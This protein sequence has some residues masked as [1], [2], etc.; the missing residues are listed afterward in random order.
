MHSKIANES[1]GRRRGERESR[2]ER[3]D[4]IKNSGI[5]IPTVLQSYTNLGKIAIATINIAHN[6]NDHMLR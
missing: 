3:G 4:G 6:S 1:R 5:I 2:R